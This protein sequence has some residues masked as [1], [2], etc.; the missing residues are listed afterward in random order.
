MR[1]TMKYKFFLQNEIQI[2]L[3]DPEN[4]ICAYLSSFDREFGTNNANG[5]G[6]DMYKPINDI[7][8]FGTVLSTWRK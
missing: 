7:I 8:S 2:L 3:A 4:S 6:D 5:F 1:R